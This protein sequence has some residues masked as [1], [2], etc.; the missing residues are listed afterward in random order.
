VLDGI[1]M[2]WLARAAGDGNLARANL[3]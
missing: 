1:G 2:S 3:G